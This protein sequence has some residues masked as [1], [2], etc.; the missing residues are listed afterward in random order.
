MSRFCTNCGKQLEDG[1]I[2]TCRTNAQPQGN[3]YQQPVQPKGPDMEWFNDKKNQFVSK[4]KNMFSEILP[5]LKAP[6]TRGKELADSNSGNVGIEF[7]ITKAV[8]TVLVLI[9]A[10]IGIRIELGDYA[11]YLDLPYIRMFLVVII[12]TAGIDFLEAFL[13]NVLTQAFKGKTNF[14]ATV[15]VIG[16]RGLYQTIGI[17]AG[18]IL[19]LLA[20]AAGL[21]VMALCFCFAAYLEQ[22][23][24]LVSVENSE[25]RKLYTFYVEKICCIIITAIIFLIIGTSV[26]DAFSNFI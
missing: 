2:C 14:N 11:E 6:I 1:E 23:L 13:L 3:P 19:M 26:L 5:I 9:I 22:H 12:F 4:T 17:L 16:V 8:I 25:D 10:L 21:V 24:F 18:A 7:I 20:P 15:S